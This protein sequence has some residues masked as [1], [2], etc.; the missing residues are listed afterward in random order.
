MGKGWRGGE[1]DEWEDALGHF[2]NYA[3]LAP[4]YSQMEIVAD[5]VADKED[6]EVSTY[7]AQIQDKSVANWRRAMKHY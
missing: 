3:S 7:T 5:N 2:S 6:S 4:G 1:A